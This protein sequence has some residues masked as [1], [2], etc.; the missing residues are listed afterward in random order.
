MVC[1]SAFFNRCSKNRFESQ[2][3]CSDYMILV[4]GLALVSLTCA[5]HSEYILGHAEFKQEE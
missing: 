5:R 3:V 2:Y 4:I 1:A